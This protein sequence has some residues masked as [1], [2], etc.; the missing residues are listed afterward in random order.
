MADYGPTTDEVRAMYVTGTPPHRVTVP[1]GNDEFDRWLAQHDAEVAAKALRQ[2]A[3]DWQAGEWANVP[4]HAD[5]VADRLGAAQHVSD[6]LRAEA[7]RTERSG[8]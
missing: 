4:R 6:W 8:R 2:A 1:A 7:D 3:D 5:R